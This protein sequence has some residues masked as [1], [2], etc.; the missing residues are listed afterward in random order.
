MRYTDDA[1]YIG[2]AFALTGLK[3]ATSMKVVMAGPPDPQI[4]GRGLARRMEASG[5]TRRRRSPRAG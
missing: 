5:W 1:H 4:T 2:G 3:W